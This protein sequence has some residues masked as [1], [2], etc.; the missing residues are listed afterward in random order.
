MSSLSTAEKRLLL[1][2]YLIGLTGVLQYTVVTW[3][4][5]S[6]YPG[7][8]IGFSESIG[9]DFTLNFL[10]DLGRTSRFG[11]GENPTAFGYMATLA[12][13]GI[14][15]TI[16]FGTLSYY[17]TRTVGKF[18][19]NLCFIL[20]TIAGIGYIGVALNPIDEGYWIHVKFVQWG[21]IG[22]WCMTLVC[23]FCIFKSPGFPNLYG[24][25]LLLFAV[26]LGLQICVMLFGPRS[27][28]S[29]EALR[30]QVIAQKVVVYSEIL[31]MAFLA[32]GAIKAL[33]RSSLSVP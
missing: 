17:F 28:T 9:Y 10:S 25:I 19:A 32:I 26:M 7:G 4:L 8:R 18:A 22:F 11:L 21:F 33:N 15:T 3:W 30:L 27:W 12:S 20:G 14:S 5:M 13:A 31:V 29:D 6:V 2:G 23:A 1:I 16:F 24:Y